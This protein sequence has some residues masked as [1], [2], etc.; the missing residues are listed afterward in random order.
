[1]DAVRWR[2]SGDSRRLPS[3]GNMSGHGH[4]DSHTS[5]KGVALL[6]AN[7]ALFLAFSEMGGSITAREA[8][9]KNLEAANL[10][11]F[12]Q[13]KTIRRTTVQVAAEQIEAQ[14]PT[15][16][17]PALKE[18]MQKRIGDWRRTAD[19]YE[20]EPETGEGRKELMARAKQQ[21]EKRDNFKLRNEI[22][23]VS[24]AVLQIAIV[25]CSAMIITGIGALVWVAGGLGILATILLAIATIAPNLLH[26]H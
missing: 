19:R 18:A 21:E 5:N 8:Q 17:D 23:E 10:W 24:S 13:A 22:F 26:F 12:F 15:I 1:V 4:A 9:E 16:N 20:T 6:I 3:G 7:L 11:N 25:L 14:L 2:L